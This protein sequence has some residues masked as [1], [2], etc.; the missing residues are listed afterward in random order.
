MAL[1]EARSLSYTYPKSS[2][3]VVEDWSCAFE[4][5]QVSA[6]TGKSG[7]G[8]STRLFLLAL[9]VKPTGGEIFFSGN[10]VDNLK[11]AQ[12]SNIRARDFG[13]VFQDS[14]LDLT[15]SVLDN[16]TESSLYRGANRKEEQAKAV[17]LLAR[18]EV[19]VPL[20]CRP[21]QISG[22][23]AQRI[24]L[25]RALVGNPKVIFAD[26]PTGNLDVESGT[27]VMGMLKEAAND[28]ASVILVTHDPKVAKLSDQRIDISSL[29]VGYEDE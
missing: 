8:K 1:L 21:G 13:F 26:E 29:L 23:Q 25:C 18:V 10:R 17:E 7:C 2:R 5:G 16:V 11:D 22:G 24:A 27:V 28:G 15:R 20:D 19:S 9:L 4:E 12:R 14:A 3:A 6:I